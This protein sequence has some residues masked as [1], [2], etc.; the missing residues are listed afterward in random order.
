MAIH[1]HFSA[2]FAKLMDLGS[3]ETTTSIR[4]S[5]LSAPE[6]N[7]LVLICLLELEDPQH[8]S[9]ILGKLP[10]PGWTSMWKRGRGRE[11]GKRF[12]GEMSWLGGDSRR[13]PA[14]P[15]AP[16]TSHRRA[17]CIKGQ[18]GQ[19]GGPKILSTKRS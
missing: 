3:G 10:K 1:G 4:A 14:C 12:W 7:S 6:L 19:V 17:L 9:S 13:E 8:L 2:P 16:V 18:C 15:E 11:E 5:F